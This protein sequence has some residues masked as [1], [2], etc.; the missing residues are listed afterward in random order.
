VSETT[1]RDGRYA[2]GATA[3]FVIN[4]AGQCCYTVNAGDSEAPYFARFN[5]TTSGFTKFTVG[6]ARIDAQFLPTTGG[7]TDAFSIVSNADADGDGFTDGV[8]SYVEPTSQQNCGVPTPLA[9]RV[10]AGRPI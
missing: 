3:C 1:A 9:R 2:A 4:G 5:S 10:L 7:F 8:E 6:P